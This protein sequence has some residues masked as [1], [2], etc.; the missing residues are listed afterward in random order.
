MLKVTEK[1][2]TPSTNVML[3]GSV[4]ALSE[5]VTVTLSEKFWTGWPC[6]FNASNCTVTGTPICTLRGR[7]RASWVAT[8]GL[9]TLVVAL[10][11][12][13]CWCCRSRS[14]SASRPC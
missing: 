7:T 10:A 6:A 14:R 5:L 11:T 1:T 2:A 8:A 13:P 4:A 9:I 12:T 3:P